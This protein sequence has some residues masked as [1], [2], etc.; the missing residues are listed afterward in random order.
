MSNQ[1]STN[2]WRSR[3]TTPLALSDSSVDVVR[4]LSELR[5]VEKEF[6]QRAATT[7]SGATV[8]Y[9]ALLEAWEINT[10]G[11]APVPTSQAIDET[12]VRALNQHENLLYEFV[13]AVRVQQEVLQQAGAWVVQ[14]LREKQRAE[15]AGI[16][17]AQLGAEE[18]DGECSIVGDNCSTSNKRRL[19]MRC[20][21][22]L[23]CFECQFEHT[24]LS[25]KAETN[26]A[27]CVYCRRP[28]AICTPA[29]EQPK[30]PSP[31]PSAARETRSGFLR[32]SPQRAF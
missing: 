9:S 30:T 2:D 17:N 22:A 5:Y 23:I 11:V 7:E 10:A 14:L 3:A 16:F 1:S 6:A 28:Y 32:S 24:L 19:R 21:G 4:R 18:C 27:E 31:P 20:C 8:A 15:F 12:I 26:T 29:P 25:A 13:A